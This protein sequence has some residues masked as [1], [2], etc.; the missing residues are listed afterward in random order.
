MW[1]IGDIEIDNE[2]V[3]GPMAGI[4]FLSYRDFMKPFGVGLSV[5]EM[6]SDAG[7]VYENDLTLDYIKTSSLDHPVAI[8]LFGSDSSLICKAIDIAIK[9]NPN[10]EIFDINLGCPVHKVTKTGAGSAMLKDT[11]KLETFMKEIVEHSPKPVTAKIRLGWDES[12]I[13]FLDNIKA[14]ER[15]GVKAI[16]IHARTTKQCYGGKAR[17]ELLKDLGEK[18]SVPLIISGDIYTLEDAIKAKEITKAT[19]VMVARGGVGNPHLVKQISQYFIDGTVLPPISLDENIDNL[20]KFTDL[21]IKEKGEYRAMRIL[22]G[23]APRFFFSYPNT[24]RVKTLLATSLTTKQ[25]LLDIIN[26]FKT[27]KLVNDK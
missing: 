23:I 7:L 4:T 6:V 26:D 16:A 15:A 9:T 18:M 24:K 1:K 21:I 12:S 17:Y 13:N 5:S 25:S 22:R 20:L 27:G 19:A 8:Q 14:L 11:K 2:V 3:L 10:F